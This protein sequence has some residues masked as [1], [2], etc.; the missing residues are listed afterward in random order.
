MCC[1]TRS[2]HQHHTDSDSQK[3]ARAAG[4]PAYVQE[5]VVANPLPDDYWI[6]AFPFAT[7][8]TYRDLVA[9]GLGFEGKPAS[10]R[11]VENPKNTG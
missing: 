5:D 1:N 9:Y 6:E 11:L 8:D 10:I 2:T 7:N 4:V 3:A